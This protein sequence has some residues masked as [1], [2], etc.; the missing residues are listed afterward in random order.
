MPF[1]SFLHYFKT[2][3]PGGFF[4]T[5]TD[6]DIGKTFVSCTIAQYLLKKQPGLVISPR[7]PIAS[8]ALRDQN[9]E[10]YS[11]DAVQLHQACESQESLQTVCPYLLE[12]AISPARAIAQA[13]Q[14]ITIHDLALASEVPQ[15]T[16][17]FV[18]GAGGIYSPLASD[19]LNIDLAKQLGYPVILVVGNRLGCLNHALLSINAIE[20]AGL[21]IAHIFVNNLSDQSDLENVTDLESLTSHPVSLVPYQAQT[22]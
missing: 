12:P 8:G 17:A 4:I 20:N 10:L 2:T 6:T 1:S 13:K 11:E 19:G 9:G 22:S 7:K 16:V 3:Q 5:G 21:E 15:Q 14:T 18:E